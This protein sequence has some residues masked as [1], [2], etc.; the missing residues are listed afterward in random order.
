MLQ[1]KAKDVKG[2][3]V[4]VEA[5]GVDKCMLIIETYTDRPKWTRQNLQHVLK[6][7][8]LVIVVMARLLSII[9]CVTESTGNYT[10]KVFGNGIQVECCT[11]SLL[12]S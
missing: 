10:E 3:Q 2:S 5:K 11:F 8:G 4:F 7:Y 12:C 1:E 6:K 9:N